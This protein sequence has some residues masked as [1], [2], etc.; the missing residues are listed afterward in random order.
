MKTRKILLTLT[1]VASILM[2]DCASTQAKKGRE[3]ELNP[4][5]QYEKAVVSWNYGLTDEALKY[6]DRSLSLDSSH[7][8]SWNL[9][10][11]VQFN[12]E[13]YSEAE[14]AYLKCVAIRP[15]DSETHNNL[16][17]VYQKM[18]F[19]ERAEEKYL[20]AYEIDGNANASFN[21]AKLYFSQDKLEQALDYARKSTQKNKRSAP[22]FNLQGVILNKMERTS[23][24][25]ASFQTAVEL[26]PKDMVTRVNLGVALINNHEFESARK[27]F[28]NI[29]PQ[30]Q[31]QALKDKINEY[32]ELIKQRI[33]SAQPL[34]REFQI[35]VGF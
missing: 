16:G 1:L 22:A 7:Y 5:Y 32:L 30:V 27:L 13:N 21:L 26:N 20:K 11:L 33:P 29:L 17:F 24:A 4:Q 8:D 6:L 18:G 31:D 19:P 25:I 9:L 10:G 3:N 34:C 2:A 28:E 35:N 12:K 15:E 23:E 14:A